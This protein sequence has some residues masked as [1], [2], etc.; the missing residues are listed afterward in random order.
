MVIRR[1]QP[2]NAIRHSHRRGRG[3]HNLIPGSARPHT[4]SYL[5]QSAARAD[6][7]KE[8]C[9][10]SALRISAA[11]GKEIFGWHCKWMLILLRLRGDSQPEPEFSG[12]FVHILVHTY[13]V[14]PKTRADPGIKLCPPPAPC[15]GADDDD[16]DAPRVANVQRTCQYAAA[17]FFGLAG[18]RRTTACDA[19][20]TAVS[21]AATRRG[22]PT[23]ARI[24]AD[25]AVAAAAPLPATAGR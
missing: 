24:L 8:L 19:R 9:A 13:L 3:G 4:Y 5:V 12:F 21:A 14:Q 23:D 20:A 17:L 2:I 11:A 18:A 10:R 7:L 15:P 22:P 25:A 16:D 6:S 1:P